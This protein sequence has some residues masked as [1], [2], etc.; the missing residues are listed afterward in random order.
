MRKIFNKT[1]AARHIPAALVLSALLSCG[2]GEKGGPAITGGENGDCSSTD[3]TLPGRIDVTVP[4]SSP[5]A[6]AY[7]DLYDSSPDAG[8]FSM[9]EM[10]VRPVMHWTCVDIADRSDRNSLGLSER[11]R[12]LQYHLLCQSLAGLVNRA[13]AE[14]RTNVGIWLEDSQ[15][16][17]SRVKATLGPE[18]GRQAGIQLISKDYGD[19]EGQRVNVR[20]LVDGYVLC[21]VEG[22]PESAVA[23]SVA[24][25]VFNSIIVDVRDKTYFD[26]L[27][28]EMKY[29]A[30]RKSTEDAWHEFR[31]RCSNK[32]LVLMP[33]QTGEL[34][35]YA[36]SNSLFVLNLNKK[37]GT[38]SG[39]T[40]TALM[41]EVLAWLEPGASVLGWESAS[42]ED[43][44]V[45]RIS[46]AG[47]LMLAADWS[48][49][50]TL[51]SAGARSHSP[52]LAKVLNP[53][54]I[55]YTKPAHYVSFF[56]SDG[57]NY[58]WVMNAFDEEFYSEPSVPSVKFSFGL[59]SQALE[60]LAP[61]H[62]DHLLASQQI[63]GNLME[64]FG[65]GYFYVD[66]YASKS[67]RASG[68]RLL[69]ERTASAMR[70]HRLKVLHLI[71]EDV[72]SEASM[73]AYRAFAEANDQ[74]EGIV[75]IQYS[76]YNGGGGKVLWVTN[77][78]GYD[79]PV[80]T[81]GYSLWRGSD[82]P[83]QGSPQEIGVRMKTLADGL[84]HD[85]VCVHAWST[86]DGRKGASAALACL[87]AAGKTF[88]AVPVQELVW[89][90]RM[91]ERREQTL[92]YLSTI[93]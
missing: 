46:A 2:S 91:A 48:Y 61:V 80:V 56:L 74:L 65:G 47:K 38:S 81:A 44:F 11:T 30:T 49:N 14:G 72:D 7:N 34:R 41:D 85:L 66:N 8:R 60:Q 53:R 79:I 68:L 93:R 13:L 87:N 17:Y 55:D 28:M 22:N 64:C 26:G 45:S 92:K 76:P 78:E 62:E 90:I 84:T 52:A 36:V 35:E 54:D 77:K 59:C 67:D 25:H 6:V 15:A 3:G 19:Y 16:P 89:R 32:A 82:A 39:G 23:A 5:E 33:V 24:S 88:E 31:D 21:D 10:P 20:D 86:F 73:E 75:V 83:G 29:D 71:A 50:H 70:A 63:P 18:I 1:G 42:G 58:Q 69:A 12:G 57:D 27:G 40:N 43:V 9:P 37:N 51:T 4:E